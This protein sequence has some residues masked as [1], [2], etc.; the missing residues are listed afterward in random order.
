MAENEFQFDEEEPIPIDLGEESDSGP[1]PVPAS[2]ASQPQPVPVPPPAQ[3]DS[4]EATLTVE[5]EIEPIKLEEG[6]GEGM[7]ALKAFGSG[8]G[9]ERK[10]DFKRPMNLTGQGATRFRIFNA[11]IAAGPLENLERM[12]NEWLD[13]NEIEVK[14][15]GQFIGTMEGKR[16]EPN[17]LVL[18]WY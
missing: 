1:T 2:E 8:A 7:A 4:D 14:A 10:T 15:V 18:V 9:V 16:A 11:K 12:I 3:D 6:T 13:E 17:L 5:E